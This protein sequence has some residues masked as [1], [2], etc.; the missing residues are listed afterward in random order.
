MLARLAPILGTLTVLALLTGACGEDRPLDTGAATTTT[1]VATTDRSEAQG[2]GDVRV[3]GPLLVSNR[4]HLSICVD[5]GGGLNI[6]NEDVQGVRETLEEALA[7]RPEIPPEYAEREVTAGCPA[8]TA[9][10]GSPEKFLGLGA[11]SV[12]TPSEHRV[13]VYLL[14]PEVYAATFGSDPYSF[15]PEEFLCEG[16]ACYP[17]TF[18]LYVSSSFDG[19]VL[20]QGLLDSLHLLLPKPNNPE[21]ILDWAACERGEQPHPDYSCD[22]YE[23]WKRDQ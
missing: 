11:P 20:R 2:G 23:E 19:N 3:E 7:A 17:I 14:P 6:S 18:G 21:P 22:Q 4:S 12:A 16:D 10:L 15:G 9:R 8:P 5:G 13:F 1:A